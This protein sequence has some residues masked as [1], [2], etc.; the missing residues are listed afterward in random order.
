[1]K[2]PHKRNKNKILNG[3]VNDTLSDMLTRI[4]N[5]QL[6]KHTKVDVFNTK[7]NKKI[8]EILEKAGFIKTYYVLESSKKTTSNQSNPSREI[9]IYLKYL[10][11]AQIPC[12]SKIRR[13]S[14]PGLRLYSGYKDLP[15]CLNGMGL[16]ILT[17][18]KGVM[19]DQ[20][21]KRK[22]L[23]GELLCSIY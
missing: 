13:I 18:S 6:A 2:Q 14:S 1:M 10:T 19:T 17:T 5:A 21:A 20:E 9:T 8:T 15:K 23:G 16:I 3:M 12:I 22:K 4:R 7:T 11:Q